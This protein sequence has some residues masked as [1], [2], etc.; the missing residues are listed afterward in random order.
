ML[1]I[2]TVLESYT[3]IHTNY[4][5]EFTV[6]DQEV[7]RFRMIERHYF[8]KKLLKSFDF[9]FGFCMPNSCN[10]CEH[11]YDMPELTAEESES[12]CL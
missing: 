12:V 6:G 7:N 10:T 1:Y 8:G 4:R 9:D 5:I 2:H 3:R 11:I